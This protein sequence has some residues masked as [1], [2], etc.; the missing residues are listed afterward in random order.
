M[1]ETVADGGMVYVKRRGGDGASSGATVARVSQTARRG[2]ES[3]V[4]SSWGAHVVMVGGIGIRGAGRGKTAPHDL[5]ANK[6]DYPYLKTVHRHWPTRTT[7]HYPIYRSRGPHHFLQSVNKIIMC[8]LDEN[9]STE[10][11]EKLSLAFYVL[12]IIYILFYTTTS[13]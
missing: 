1:V 13:I 12:F 9:R 10:K 2:V 4:D 6:A 5:S 11:G 8:D 7:Q 3:V